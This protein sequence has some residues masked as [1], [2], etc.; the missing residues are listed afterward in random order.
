MKRH[1]TRYY[2]MSHLASLYFCFCFLHC[3]KKPCKDNVGEG[4]RWG[5]KSS[6]IWK[7]LT[8]PTAELLLEGFSIKNILFVGEHTV[9]DENP[10]IHEQKYPTLQRNIFLYRLS[11]YPDIP[12]Q[13]SSTLWKLILKPKSC[14]KRHMNIFIL[15]DFWRSYSIKITVPSIY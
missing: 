12:K 1:P 3:K 9:M 15:I 13:K 11:F 10:K 7:K 2:K 6:I 14:S 5:C 8:L 4:V